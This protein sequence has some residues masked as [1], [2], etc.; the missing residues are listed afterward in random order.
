MTYQKYKLR[1]TNNQKEIKIPI[2]IKWDFLDRGD[3]VTQ[4]ETDV[5]KDIIN[6]PEDFEVD[7]FS[8]SGD[9]RVNS[10]DINYEFYFYNNGGYENSYGNNF[11]Q[12]ELIYNVNSV[13]NSFFKLDFYDTTDDKSQKNYFTIILFPY[14][15][16]FQ[17]EVPVPKFKLDYVRRSEGY[18]IYWLKNKDYVGIDTF[19]MSAKFFNAKQGVYHKFLTR[20][21]DIKNFNP[22]NNF[23]YRVK[24]DYNTLK[25]NVIDFTDGGEELKGWEDHPIKWFEYVNP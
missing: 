11:T 21:I 14:L 25:Y 10:S 17:G 5:V 13:K 12:D 20:D 4:Y 15:S 6:P 7:K 23:Y 3:L 24:L 22:Q 2:E 9:N 19:Y 16:E 1:I 18:F 8:F